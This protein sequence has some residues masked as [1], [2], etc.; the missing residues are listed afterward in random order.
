[1][2]STTW[3]T[4][5]APSLGL[6]PGLSGRGGG[7][8]GVSGHL[9]DRGGHLLHGRR[10]LAHPPGL[11]VRALAGLL[12]LGRKFAGGV[13]HHPGHALQ[14]L[15]GVDHALLA[16]GAGGLQ[17]R[18][19]LA[20][21]V[22]SERRASSAASSPLASASPILALSVAT[23]RRR[24]SARSPSSLVP[25]TSRAAPSSP[26]A[27]ASAKRT[28]RRRGPPMPR[29]M[30][31]DS[32]AH[33]RK[34][35]SDPHREHPPWSAGSSPWPGPRPGGAWSRPRPESFPPPGPRPR[36]VPGRCP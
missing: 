3:P 14:L 1:M 35:Q 8:G 10:R 15:G 23:M 7:F 34:G 36:W 19:G 30:A 5:S 16:R 27:T 4:T 9:D 12:D 20:D 6:L 17:G 28:V 26:R 29:M 22:R 25:S 18:L 33:D 11:L 13:G 31:R 24:S 2:P 21:R 32:A